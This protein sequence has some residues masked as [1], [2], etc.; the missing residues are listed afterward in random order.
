MRRIAG[1]IH[2]SAS[3]F[4][5]ATIFWCVEADAQV[6]V[7]F[8]SPAQPLARSLKA[9]GSATN[10]DVGFSASHVAG[11]LAPSLKANLTVDDA[12]LRVLSGTGL[13]P[14]HLDDHTI[15]IAAAASFTSDSPETKLLRAEESTPAETTTSPQHIENLIDSSSDLRLT[16][17]DNPP[18]QDAANS[19]TDGA[20]LL[21]NIL[22]TRTRI[23]G[24]APAS[25]VITVD[26]QVI[27]R[28]GLQNLGDVIRS[29]P[30]RFGGGQNPGTLGASGSQN[31]Y[32]FTGTSTANLRC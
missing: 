17:A 12:L 22:A 5:V 2:F 23:R 24:A 30:Q 7:H 8:D 4:V 25:P 18:A 13:R 11:L 21:E 31:T 27:E 26:R 14:Q 19:D 1:R 16:H 20:R 3:A 29:L 32:S 9:I 15:V 28:S 6:L 10:T